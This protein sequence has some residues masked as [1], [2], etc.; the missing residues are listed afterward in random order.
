M[1]KLKL[2]GQWVTTKGVPSMTAKLEAVRK[3]ETPTSIIDIRSFLGFANY[4][5][6]FIPNHADI[7]SPLTMLTKRIHHG[8]GVFSNIGHLKS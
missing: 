1:R 8:I 3:W 4:Y 7:A 5:Q 6:I 2:L